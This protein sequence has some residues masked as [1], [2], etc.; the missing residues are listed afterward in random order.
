MNLLFENKYYFLVIFL[1]GVAFM[2]G[3]YSVL[4]CQKPQ[5]F[6]VLF[7]DVGQGDGIMISS[8]RKQILID[9]GS[10]AHVLREHLSRFMPWGD[11]TVEMI[12][13]THPDT[14]HIGALAETFHY[15]DTHFILETYGE[16]DTG[17]YRA[18]KSLQEDK[19][20]PSSY[21]K[22]GERILFPNGAILEVIYPQE[23]VVHTGSDLNDASIV[24]RLD[25]KEQSFL[26]T[27][28]ISSKKEAILA[29]GEIDVLKVAH[30]GSKS[31]TSEVFLDRAKPKDAIISSGR[32]NRYG[33]PTQ[34]TLDR[35]RLHN[36]RVLRTDEMGSIIYTCFPEK[37]ECE[38]TR[39]I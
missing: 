37:D 19:K 5:D 35:L 34:E 26:F 12:I 32:D 38:V 7:F 1:F 27:G 3:L 18:W 39:E 20:I 25:F 28:D 30:H 33:H 24:M 11:S 8:G 31:S 9:G 14:D 23:K 13:A 29:I 16:K 36:V 10:D 6:Q 4:I 17:V 15:Y 21:T 22:Q 2:L